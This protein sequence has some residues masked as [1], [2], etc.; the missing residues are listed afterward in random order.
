MPEISR[1]YGI[2]ISMYYDDHNPP[3]FHAR[4]GGDRAAVEI[5]SLRVLEGKLPP[6]VL[7]LVV[8]WAS[9]HQSELMDNWNETQNDRPPRRIPALQ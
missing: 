1:F 9:Q 2:V 6:R 3:H 7:G 4:H 5:P 8:R